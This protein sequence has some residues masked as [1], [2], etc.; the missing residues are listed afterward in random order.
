MVGGE[1]DGDSL[2]VGGWRFAADGEGATDE[3]KKEGE[4]IH[5]MTSGGRLAG[6]REVLVQIER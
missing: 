2:Q 1:E 3:E 6:V 5:P 4:G